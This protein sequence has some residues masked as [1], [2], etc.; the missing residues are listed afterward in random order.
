[1]VFY[2][3]WNSI[4]R[5]TYNIPVSGFRSTAA[6]LV[7]PVSKKKYMYGSL[8]I[9]VEAKMTND[10]Q[11]PRIYVGSNHAQHILLDNGVDAEV[12]ANGC[13]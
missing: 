4:Y 6:A 11:G 13:I 7:L 8:D 10:P 3:G 5:N 9:L 1:V 12:D 2:F